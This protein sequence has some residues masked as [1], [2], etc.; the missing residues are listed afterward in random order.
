LKIGY[1]TEQTG[2]ESY[3][4]QNSI[5]ALEDYVAKVNDAGGINGYK[6]QLV[7]YDTRSEVTDAVSVLKR[8]IEQDGVVAVIGPSWSAAGIPI[9]EIADTSKIPVVATTASNINV[10]VTEDGKLHPYMFRVCFIDP[11][12]G[13]AQADFAYNKLGLRKAAL[14]TDISSPYT[15]G[16]HQYF[17]KHFVEL[18]GQIVAT[19]GYNQGDTEFRAQLA[20]IKDAA[21]DLVVMDAYTFKDLGLASQQAEALG[22][23]GK[24][25]GGDGVF[26]P[27]LLSMSGPQLEGAYVTT[28]VS[29]TAP[30]FAPFNAEYEKKHPGIKANVYTYY[31]LD[32]LMMIEYGIREAVK[33]GDPTPTAIRDAIESMKDVQLFT[34]KVTM[35]PD[36]HNPHNKPLL[37]MSIVDS[38]WSLVETFTPK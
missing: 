21:P 32:A 18:G 34:S 28:G 7:T 23:K 24:F 17:E 19:E 15:V 35:E 10:T 25:M 11:Y 14:L 22:L 8:M 27:E 20:K 2:V 4:A 30:E 12:Q 26:V 5:P 29:E 3:I 1:L 16:L 31:G 13:Y 36:T 9:A 38:Q 6:L 37:I 33:K